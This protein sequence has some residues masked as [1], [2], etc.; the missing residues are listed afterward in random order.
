MDSVLEEKY[1]A[2]TLTEANRQYIK[3]TYEDIKEISDGLIEQNME[4]YRVLANA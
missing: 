4:A 2:D 1:S 3:L